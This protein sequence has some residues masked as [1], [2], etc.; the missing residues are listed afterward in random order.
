MNSSLST[1]YLGDE[2]CYLLWIFLSTRYPLSLYANRRKLT[3][4]LQ[5]ISLHALIVESRIFREKS[6]HDMWYELDKLTS[7]VC[8]M[9]QY[10]L[11]ETTVCNLSKTNHCIYQKVGYMNTRI[12]R[13]FTNVLHTYEHTYCTNI[14]KRFA[15]IWTHV[16]YE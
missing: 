8:C 10:S 4:Y 6:G 9:Y 12:V 7:N 2:L 14:Y 11:I 5:A 16:L 15:H 1:S 3:V 13:I